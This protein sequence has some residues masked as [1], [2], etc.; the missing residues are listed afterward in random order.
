MYTYTLVHSLSGVRRADIT[1]V[2]ADASWKTSM[3]SPGQGSVTLLLRQDEPLLTRNEW[4]EYTAHWMNALVVSWNGVAVYAGLIASR[5]WDAATGKLTVDLVELREMMSWRLTTDVAEFTWAATLSISGKSKRGM[6]RALIQSGMNRGDAANWDFPIDLGPDEAGGE[7]VSAYSWELR[8]I[9]QMVSEIQDSEGGPD[10]HFDPVWSGDLM[11]GPLIWRLRL[12]TPRLAGPTFE[13]SQSADESPLTGV[14]LLEDGW[15]MTTGI[16]VAGEG[17]EGDMVTGSAGWGAGEIISP[18]R[19][20][21]IAYKQVASKA[22]LD[23]LGAEELNATRFPA[24]LK[25]FSV[26][27]DDVVHPGALRIGSRVRAWTAG[28]EFEPEGR[29]PGYLVGLSGST[30]RSLDLEL[31]PL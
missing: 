15:K 24:R 10:V 9:E 5:T 1:S 17:S 11:G 25:S 2:V 8:V 28:D 14:T 26:Q 18:W 19:D 21:S 31:V 12:G 3:P 16:M 29:F 20:R 4:R 22:V 7:S 23:S 6:V 30:K 27:I 13:M